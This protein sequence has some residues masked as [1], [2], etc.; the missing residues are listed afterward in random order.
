MPFK[1][2]FPQIQDITVR[3]EESGKG[4]YEDF[5]ILLYTI[6]NPPGEYIDCSNPLCYGGGFSIGQILRQMVRDKKNTF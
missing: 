5:N 3:V 4:V 1:E 6:D 2:A